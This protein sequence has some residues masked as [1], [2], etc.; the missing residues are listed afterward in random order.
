MI[1]KKERANT[2][3]PQYELAEAYLNPV[4]AKPK[5]D[6]N[7]EADEGDEG[8]GQWEKMAQQYEEL[9][10]RVV[11][12]FEDVQR[13]NENGPPVVKVPNKP[14]KEEW[15]RHQVTHTPFADWCPHCAAARNARRNHPSHGRKG[16]MVPDIEAGEGPTTVSLDYMYL[17]ER[18]GKYRE[19]KHNPLYLVVIEHQHGRC[20]AHQVPNK[21]VNDGAYW[22]PKRVLQDLENNGLGKARFLVKTD[23]EPSIVCVQRAL[24]DLKSDI[25]PINSPVGE[26]ACNGRV[27][28]AIRR[29]QEKM[30]TLRHQFEHCIG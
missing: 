8:Q 20:W 14:T 27:E 7:E 17:H 10:T 15:E 29:V 30:R 9:E 21:G 12:Q 1:Q 4:H 24:Q 5:Q 11:E 22:V 13:G 6:E 19:V 16:K 28:N 25:I 3:R 2:V 26:S 18:I 23:Q